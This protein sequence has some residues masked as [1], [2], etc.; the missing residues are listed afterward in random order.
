MMQKLQRFGAA[1]FVPVLLF[2][3]AGIVVALGCLFNNAT[4]FGS[5]ASP[6]TG[7][8]KV[9]DTISA[10]VGLYLIRNVYYLLLDCQ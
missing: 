10:G 2:S 7:W 8:Y 1:M 6:T 4:I 5:L 9:W 3:F